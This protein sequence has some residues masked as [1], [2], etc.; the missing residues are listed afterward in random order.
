MQTTHIHHTDLYPSSL[1]MGSGEFGASVDREISFALLDRFTELGGTFI[2]TAKIYNDWVPGETSRSEKLIGEWMRARKNRQGII[3]AT[4]G[5]HYDLAAPQIPR[6]SPDEILSDLN[7]SLKHLQTDVI[8]LY[9]L[10]RDD[11]RRPVA[12]ILTILEAQVKAGKIRYYGCSNWRAE[13]IQAA[14]EFA[15]ENHLQGFS[16]VQNMWN[17]ARINPDGIADPTI[18]IMDEALLAYHRA[19]NLAAI[20]FS[21]QANGLF[22]KMA[23]GGLDSLLP[24][25]QKMYLNADTQRRFERLLELRAATGLTIT[26]IVLGYLLS[27]PFPTI[28]VFSSRS[29]EQLQDTLSAASVRL[30]GEQVAF[31]L[32]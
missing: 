31:L 13:R 21:S 14:Q 7:A 18:V 9:W 17:L 12:E 23:S 16:A 8:D 25:H 19:S 4:K 15:V 26:Q 29:Q 3:L 10:H 24:M 30:T 11:P 28:P 20:P 27:Q 6:V 2:D 1:C 5:A 22:Q 32:S